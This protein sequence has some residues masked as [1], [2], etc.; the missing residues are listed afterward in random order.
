MKTSTTALVAILAALAFWG[1]DDGTGP[2]PGSGTLVGTWLST[3][4]D[5]APGVRDQYRGRD[6]VVAVFGDDGTW[7]TLEY[8][9][10][11]LSP[12][13]ESGVYELGDSVGPIRAITMLGDPPRT[14]T[15]FAGIFRVTGDRLQLEVVQPWQYTP[16][17]VEGGFGS[18]LDDG[19]QTGVY[20]IQVFERQDPRN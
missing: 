3:G 15:I 7:V 11:R 9:P 18:T 20:W 1:C 10:E 12:F 8:P 17:T 4:Y 5:V 2:E 19:A 6:S 16:P 13:E 14:D